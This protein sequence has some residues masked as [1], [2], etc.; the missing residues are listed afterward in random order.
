MLEGSNLTIGLWLSLFTPAHLLLP[1]YIQLLMKMH[2]MLWP[3]S[4]RHYKYLNK[5]KLS[6]AF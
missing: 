5:R 2:V 6:T 4:C 3:D 1:Q